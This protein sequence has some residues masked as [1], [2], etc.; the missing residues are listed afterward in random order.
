MQKCKNCGAEI[1]YIATSSGTS[2]ICEAERK[3]FV[4]ENGRLTYGYLIHTCKESEKKE[5]AESR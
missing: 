2:A 1:R 5:D 3:T 4:T